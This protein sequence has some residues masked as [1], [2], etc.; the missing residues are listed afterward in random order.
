MKY[1]HQHI[2]TIVLALTAVLL[3]AACQSDEP[4]GSEQVRSRRLSMVLGQHTYEGQVQ[5]G[6]NGTRRALPS[7]FVVYEDLLPQMAMEDTRVRAY[8][9]H[10]DKQDFQGDFIYQ[11]YTM[12]GV[13]HRVWSAQVPI[14]NGDYYLYGFMP[15]SAINNVKIEPIDASYAK[16]AKLTLSDVAAVT[17]YDPCVIVGVRGHENATDYIGDVNIQ[18]GNFKYN[19]QSD[20]EFIYLL[21]DHLYAA[22]ELRMNI[23]EQ[24]SQLRQ[25][26]VKEVTL[27]SRKVK[28]TSLTVELRQQGSSAD[29]MTSPT[30]TKTDGE[31]EAQTIYKPK[32]PLYLPQE[33]SSS[34]WKVDYDERTV[35]FMACLAPVAGNTQFTMTT[36]YDV[37][38]TKDH[39]LRKDC[40]AENLLEITDLDA[41]EKSIIYMTVRPSYLYVLGHYDLDNPV[42]T[43]N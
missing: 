42:F 40:T 27:K 5:N 29:P 13:E 4:N 2:A 31:S 26:K 33:V 15:S 24:Y 22:L 25:I 18:W 30:F 39:L 43:I 3:L 17:P 12:D 32:V 35:N 41:G 20:G 36:T 28:K 14:D 10:G 21:L 37:Y 1:G 8:V 11:I 7:D 38:D 9:T 34:S 23:E 16:G 6:N 19:A